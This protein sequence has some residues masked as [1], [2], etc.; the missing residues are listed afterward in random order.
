MKRDALGG[1]G[2]FARLKAMAQAAAQQG[3][4]AM[5]IS[6]VHALFA[7][8]PMRFSPYSPSSRLFFNGLH[9]DA[10]GVLGKARV[11]AAMKAA[12]V[13]DDAL[14]LEQSGLVDWPE[15]ARV[16]W[17]WLRALHQSFVD[18]PNEAEQTA[19]HEFVVRAGESLEQHARFEALDGLWR[20]QRAPHLPAGDWRQWPQAFQQPNSAEVA[21]FIRQHPGE[22][23]F[24]RFVQWLAD[25]SL[26]AAHA[27]ALSSGMAI[28][29]ISDLA[30]GMD[31]GGSHAWS[32]REG[33]IGGAK[34]RCATRSV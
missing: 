32:R 10:S 26:A 7:A 27:G 29:L 23:D 5:A 4:H 15:V 6:P 30:V 17:A 11:H 33:R 28:G 31:A 19:Y 20:A 24:H 3:A 13:L 9:A 12:G 8:D 34:R 1:V 25:T 14:A 2:D 21:H 16:K 18:R 22:V